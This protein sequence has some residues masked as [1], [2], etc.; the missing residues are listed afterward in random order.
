MI[1]REGYI[2]DRIGSHVQVRLH[3]FKNKKK[4]NNNKLK[5]LFQLIKARKI[6]ILLKLI[7]T[8]KIKILLKLIK[9]KILM[10]LKR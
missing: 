8:K 6:K 7:K 2:K 10:R 9:R 3:I 5:K 4:N 1:A